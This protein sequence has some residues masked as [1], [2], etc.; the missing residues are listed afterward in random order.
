M[1]E[2][3]LSNSMGAPVD[4]GRSPVACARD[5]V[6]IPPNRLDS[7]MIVSMVELR[8]WQRCSAIAPGTWGLGGPASQEQPPPG[9]G[10]IHAAIQTIGS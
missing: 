4:E 8:R 3:R 5:I 2:N 9:D 10:G 7:S 1:N 6:H